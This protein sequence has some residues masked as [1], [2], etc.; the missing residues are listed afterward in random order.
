M[1]M[2]GIAFSAVL[3]CAALGAAAFDSPRPDPGNP[4][5]RMGYL[6]GRRDERTDLCNRF[7]KHSA[8]AATLLGEA[9]MVLIRTFC[10]GR[11]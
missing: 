1:K 3:A 7:E 11:F 9:R 5:Y 6:A 10:A 2:A 4:Q 8:V